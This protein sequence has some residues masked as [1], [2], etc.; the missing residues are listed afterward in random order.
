MDARRA[1]P[2]DPAAHAVH[3]MDARTHARCTAP[4]AAHA[5][6]KARGCGTHAVHARPGRRR[7]V[8]ADDARPRH[9][10]TRSAI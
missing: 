4:T 3:A 9:A 2:R 10:R 1:T 7:A 8:M 5:S 6:A